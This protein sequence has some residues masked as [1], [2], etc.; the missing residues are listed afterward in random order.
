MGPELL[1]KADY[2]RMLE[3]HKERFGNAAE[4]NFIIIGNFDEAEL[5]KYIAQYIAS[6]PAKKGKKEV[7]T[8]DNMK[9]KQGDV[10]GEFILATENKQANYAGIWTTNQ[11]EY[12]A[13]N[14][15]MASIVGQLMS[16]NLTNTVREQEGAAYSPHA[17]ASLDKTFEPML[18]IQAVFGI[19]ANKK[20]KVCELTTKALTDLST[21]VKEEELNKVKEYMLKAIDQN[22]HENRYWMNV[23]R[24]YLNT[25]VDRNASYRDIINGLTPEKIQNFTKQ[26]LASGNRIQFIMLPTA[27]K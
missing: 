15:I 25:G 1:E 4:F 3:I 23:M 11:I 27:E 9:V 13:E 20:D 24:A 12:T 7:A 6:L 2:N 19:N 14:S 8:D 17:S 21:S 10:Y 22:E 26:I 5:K 16:T 18:I